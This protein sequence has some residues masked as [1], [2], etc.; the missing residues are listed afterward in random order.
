MTIHQA[1]HGSVEVI[2]G[3]MF[4]GKTTEL[5]RQVTRAQIAKQKV[6]IFK[7]AMDTRYDGKD[8]VSHDTH[9]V[10]AV[11][12]ERAVD[13]LH[14]LYDN[15]RMVAIDEVQFFD[16]NIIRIVGKLAC[17]GLRVVCT[18]L[19]LDYRGV[20]FGPMPGLLAVA[21]SISKI[22]A[23]CTV[24]GGN[25]TRTQRVVRGDDPSLIFVG[26]RESYQA[27]CRVHFDYFDKNDMLPL[28][29]E[30]STLE[31]HPQQ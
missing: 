9:S 21:D 8:I 18:G 22:H 28:A 17:R 29:E 20:P 27:R 11:P 4:S 19:D 16:N 6:Q 31:E 26:E 10:T 7:S 14:H 1:G 30:I 24:C 3:P 5:I 15:T 25:A 12:V 2:C 13:I 23:I